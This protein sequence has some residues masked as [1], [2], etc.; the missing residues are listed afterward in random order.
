MSSKNFYDGGIRT[1]DPITKKALWLISLVANI[2]LASIGTTNLGPI[3][4]FPLSNAG[5]GI[6]VAGA[7]CRRLLPPVI[8][9]SAPKTWPAKATF[10]D[11]A[12]IFNKAKAVQLEPIPHIAIEEGHA[13][14]IA[15]PMHLKAL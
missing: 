3:P 6:A 4:D 11:S 8:R 5:S 14:Q 9:R 2:H 10:V 12:H 7:L 15:T 1:N 13:R